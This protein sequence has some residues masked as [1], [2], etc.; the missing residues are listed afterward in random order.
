MSM[1]NLAHEPLEASCS[2]QKS[3]ISAEKSDQNEQ[4][5]IASI[6]H[7]LVDFQRYLDSFRELYEQRLL[8]LLLSP[9]DPATRETMLSL[10]VVEQFGQFGCL[11]ETRLSADQLAGLGRAW[12]SLSR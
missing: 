4:A 11:P 5:S 12:I 9:D 2:S 7:R 3:G 6:V 8:S 10:N 1:S